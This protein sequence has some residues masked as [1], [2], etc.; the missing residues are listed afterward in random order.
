MKKKLSDVRKQF[1]K[2]YG[3]YFSDKEKLL[4]L[5]ACKKGHDWGKSEIF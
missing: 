2:Q 3:A 5:E 1:F 4:N